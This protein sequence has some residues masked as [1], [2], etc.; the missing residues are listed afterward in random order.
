MDIH[1]YI[2]GFVDGEGCFQIS[3]SL[4]SKMKLGIEV[5]P[6]FSVS[7]HK[8]SKDII[9]FLQRF[10]RC[11]GVRFSN[12]DQNYKFEVRNITDLVK[13][14]IPHFKKYSLMTCKKD[15]FERFT[16]IC[17]LIY[18]NHH[19]S[20]TGLKEILMLSEKLNIDGNKKYRRTDL[21]KMIQDESIV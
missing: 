21:L 17:E 3:F 1:S 4:R 9:L 11:G 6:S 7:Q 10:F 8:R 20:K 12:K 19:L 5:R 18:S 16:K 15:E 2:T 14:I 13:V